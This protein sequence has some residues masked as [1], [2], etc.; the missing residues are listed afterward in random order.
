MEQSAG[1]CV[2]FVHP[3]PWTESHRLAPKIRGGPWRSEKCMVASG[4]KGKF[5]VKTADGNQDTLFIKSNGTKCIRQ[6][7]APIFVHNGSFEC[8]S[9]PLARHELQSGAFDA[10]LRCARNEHKGRVRNDQ[11]TRGARER[12]ACRQVDRAG[13]AL[14]AVGC[15]ASVRRQPSPPRRLP[16]ASP[17]RQSMLADFHSVCK[18]V[19]AAVGPYSRR[20]SRLARPV[21]PVSRAI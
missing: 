5:P 21:V 7:A 14:K 15:G 8:D 11:R 17:A 9:L 3:C 16:Q 1:R 20:L 12:P 6:S 10:P 19:V 18:W 13:G 4:S 2:D